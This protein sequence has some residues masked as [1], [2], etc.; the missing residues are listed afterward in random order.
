MAYNDI[1]DTQTTE[2]DH[3]SSVTAV[4]GISQTSSHVVWNH[5]AY[6]GF[7][8]TLAILLTTGCSHTR[9]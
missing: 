6:S 8:T 7:V 3:H 2:L 1:H 5:T 9:R 4:P